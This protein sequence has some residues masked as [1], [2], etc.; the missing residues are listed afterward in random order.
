M[1]KHL[2][3]SAGICLLFTAA[4][5]ADLTPDD[6]AHRACLDRFASVSRQESM[7]LRADEV[8]R[9]PQ[10]FAGSWV[11]FFNAEERGSV[12]PRQYRVQCEALRAGRV[13]RFE[14]EPGTWRFEAPDT[15]RFATR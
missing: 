3:L 5:Q 4:A 9:A 6:G 10:E 13:T 12:E 8:Y 7:N 2:F 11:Y 15:S 14:L 1:K